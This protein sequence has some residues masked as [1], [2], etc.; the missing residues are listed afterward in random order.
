MILVFLIQ[1]SQLPAP[2]T[3]RSALLR[4]LTVRR[5][6][7]SCGREQTPKTSSSGFSENAAM[8]LRGKKPLK[9]WILGAA[10]WSSELKSSKSAAS[11]CLIL[12]DEAVY[13]LLGVLA[14]QPHPTTPACVKPATFPTRPRRAKVKGRLQ[15]KQTRLA[16]CRSG[17][18]VDPFQPIFHKR[19]L[20]HPSALC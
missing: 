12:E 9:T 5:D 3:R 6:P 7:G 19:R 17:H 2:S 10:R 18:E 20:P 8:A 11:E 1:L 13:G 14:I 15:Q 4:M 16:L